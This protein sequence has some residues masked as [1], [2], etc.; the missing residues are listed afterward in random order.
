MG[1]GGG[2]KIEGVRV[3]AWLRELDQVMEAGDGP[4]MQ[5]E[6]VDAG[7]YRVHR[8]GKVCSAQEAR[9]AIPGKT[10]FFNAGETELP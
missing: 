9:E 6:I 8:I 1:S 3:E 5:G 4:L 10:G 7:V 2:R